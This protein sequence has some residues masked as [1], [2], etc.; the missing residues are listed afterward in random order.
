MVQG[1]QGE[2]VRGNPKGNSKAD[3][4]KLEPLEISPGVLEL[5]RFMAQVRAQVEAITAVPVEMM[6]R[7][8]PTRTIDGLRYVGRL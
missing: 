6:G 8:K 3:R 5:A 7:A 2:Q 4:V 1:E